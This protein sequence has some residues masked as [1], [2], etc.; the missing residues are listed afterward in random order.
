[1][2]K[3]ADYKQPQMMTRDKIS[4]CP[5]FDETVVTLDAVQTGA[6]VPHLPSSI[7]K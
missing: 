1:L 3:T 2:F 6:V 7:E 4:E 5:G